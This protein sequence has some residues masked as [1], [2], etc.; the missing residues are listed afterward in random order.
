MTQPPRTISAGAAARK[1]G[2]SRQRV[3]QWLLK[4]RIPGA[5]KIETPWGTI[6]WK[7]PAKAKRPADDRHK[8]A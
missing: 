5:V 7:I 6:C 8:T 1:W 4:N 3:G 2:V